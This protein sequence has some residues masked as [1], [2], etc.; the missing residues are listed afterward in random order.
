MNDVLFICWSCCSSDRSFGIFL[1]NENSISMQS[2]VG[3]IR[4]SWCSRQFCCYSPIVSGSFWCTWDEVYTENCTWWSRACSQGLLWSCPSRNIFHLPTG[5]WDWR[6]APNLLCGSTSSEWWRMARLWQEIASV[7]RK[8]SEENNPWL[9]YWSGSWI[10][11]S[12]T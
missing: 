8:Y 4:F 6:D 12:I 11:W 5:N 3:W 7:V 10:P 2:D 9:H 1:D